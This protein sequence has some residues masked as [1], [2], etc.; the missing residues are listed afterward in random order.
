MAPPRSARLGLTRQCGPRTKQEQGKSLPTSHRI[1]PYLCV[2][3]RSLWVETPHKI[4]RARCALASCGLSLSA[5]KECWEFGCGSPSACGH[6]GAAH[7]VVGKAAATRAGC[8]FRSCSAVWRI[9][10]P[11]AFG[12]THTPPG[13]PPQC[14]AGPQLQGQVRLGGDPAADGPGLAPDKGLATP[15]PN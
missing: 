14:S 10:P 5:R 4:H 11:L 1:S 9:L 15:R 2:Y 8:Y 3:S 13:M 7:E 12:L 6:Q